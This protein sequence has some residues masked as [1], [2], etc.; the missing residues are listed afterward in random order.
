[1]CEALD[2]RLNLLAIEKALH[3]AI[4]LTGSSLMYLPSRPPDCHHMELLYR[5]F[6]KPC[7]RAMIHYQYTATLLAIERS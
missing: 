1:M 7:F 3:R 4:T 5:P 2:V 6:T